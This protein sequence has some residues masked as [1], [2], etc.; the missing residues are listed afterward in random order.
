MFD[1]ITIKAEQMGG[2]PC[3]RG[4][5]IPVATVVGLVG[6]GLSQTDILAEFPDL[7]PE[8]LQQ[9]LRFAA[10]ALEERQLPLLS[11]V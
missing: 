9:A 10:R 8:D 2:V 6:E 11:E 1:R 7:E 5:R 3:L 4:L